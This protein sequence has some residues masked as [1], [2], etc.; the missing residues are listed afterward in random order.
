MVR[1]LIVEDEEKIRLSLIDMLELAEHDVIVANDG[2]IGL[3]LAQAELPDLI[4]SDIMMPNMDGY[5]LFNAIKSDLA[6]VHIPF[7]FLTAL[8]SYDDVRTGMNLGADDYLTKPF[9]Y[10]QLM[11]A[12]NVRL[13]KHALEEQAR[14][15]LFAQRLV[16]LQERERTQ[17]A[18]DLET[19]IQEPLNG[20][21][22]MLNLAQ[23]TNDPNILKTISQITE[24]IANRTQNLSQRL[25]PTMMNHLNIISIIVWLFEEYKTNH[26]FNIDFERA[27][28]LPQCTLKTK[29]AIFRIVDEI[30]NN[31]R[32]HAKT[33]NITVRIAVRENRL[34]LDIR[35]DGVGFDVQQ[36]LHENTTGLQ[37]MFE[38]AT[39]LNGELNIHSIVGDGTH[40]TLELPVDVS[41]DDISIPQP[42]SEPSTNNIRRTNLSSKIRILIA[43]DYDIIRHGL[44]QIINY[45]S[46]MQ[47]V[48][49]A[50]NRSE[51]LKEVRQQEIDLIILDL[52]IDGS[53]GFDLIKILRQQVP[54]VRI[55]GFSNQ[56]QEIFVVEA[57]KSGAN[58]Y[59]LKQSSSL[60]I[61]DAIHKV[62]KGEEYIS[63]ILADSVFRWMLDSRST[64]GKVTNIYDILT[65]REREIML[66]AITGL[67][68]AEI[69]EELTISPRTVEKHRSNFMSKL[70]LKT[71]AQLIKFANENGLLT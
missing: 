59:L 50:S 46:S 66:L 28:H 22:L 58:G 45:D 31:S 43:D 70:G 49:H 53:I 3:Q 14:L 12:V 35:D 33:K 8:A 29:I 67:T 30:L 25:M 34:Y 17:L 40:V 60:E 7:I 61:I 48:G 64:T 54:D 27:G 16:D 39:L 23:Q 1:I 71:P 65:N 10:N 9:N 20:L 37:H 47:V 57:I 4:I 68:S 52:T 26:D 51:L 13:N 55:I 19:K 56:T 24:D 36:A 62:Y 15:R 38:R 41:S 11:T 2:D 32:L 63:E 21:K 69:A 18:Q 44:E 6:T 42:Q 5:E